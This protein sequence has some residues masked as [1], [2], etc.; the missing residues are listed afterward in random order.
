MQNTLTQSDILNFE[1]AKGK[2]LEQSSSESVRCHSE[3]IFKCWLDMVNR[4]YPNSTFFYDE[5]FNTIRHQSAKFTEHK[6]NHKAVMQD[7]VN[8]GGSLD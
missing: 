4:V 7:W 3:A 2:Y 5:Y 6:N 1:F 8:T